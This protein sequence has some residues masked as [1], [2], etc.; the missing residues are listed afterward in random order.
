[1]TK[2]EM[3]M[4]FINAEVSQSKT[5]VTKERIVE[6]GASCTRKFIVKKKDLFQRIFGEN[7]S[8]DLVGVL[9]GDTN[10]VEIIS[11]SVEESQPS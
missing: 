2:K 10:S 1:M 7:F 11:W 6:S 5:L 3:L 4:S 9:P 8:D